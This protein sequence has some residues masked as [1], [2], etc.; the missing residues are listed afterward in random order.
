MR[1][2]ARRWMVAMLL[3][4]VWLVGQAAASDSDWSSTL[5]QARGQTVYWNAWGG[6]DRMNAYIEWTAREMKRQFGVDVR[7]VK[8]SDT[9]EAVTR[10][11][12]EKAAGQTHRGSADVIW[13]NGENFAAMKRHGLL[14]GPFTDR[15][16][17][18][19]LVDTNTLPT[20]IDFTVPVDGLEAPWSMAQFVFLYDRVR[21][22]RPPR[23]MPALLEWARE[24]PGRFTYPQPPNFLGTTFL[25]QALLGLTDRPEALS[26]PASE[27]E[28]AELSAPLWAYLEALHPHLW[29]RG[30][31]F[32][33]NGPAQTRLL[34]DG[35]ID[36]AMAFNPGAAEAGIRSG[37][38]PETTGVFGLEGGTVANASFLAIPFN[39]RS[40]EGALVLIDFLLS[41]AAQA[42]KQ[43]PE[44]VA[45][46]TVLK[47]ES[48]SP[49][50]RALFENLPRGKAV[51]NSQELGRPLPEPHPYWMERLEQEWERRYGAR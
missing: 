15:L 16:P 46:Q 1:T 3:T 37:T 48:L 22:P 33:A 17:N 14:F 11:L 40:R 28:F 6:D 29:R 36:V 18:Y 26:A 45:G 19:A 23:T 44:H 34:A 10:V 25:K 27:A 12:A 7:H 41:P 21:V 13:I 51:P 2:F 31:V 32:P 20:L 30:R 47:L 43:D 35:E 42:R 9:A 50:D 5:A 49:E 8:L 39:A 24:H 38:L 4:A